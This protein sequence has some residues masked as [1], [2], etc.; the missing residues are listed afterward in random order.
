MSYYLPFILY[1]NKED[2][3]VYLQHFRLRATSGTNNPKVQSGTTDSSV[4]HEL[5]SQCFLNASYIL[6]HHLYRQN[7]VGNQDCHPKDM[8]QK[9]DQTQ[10][11]EGNCFI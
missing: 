2:Q 10:V 7:D 1:L 5:I 9:E 8:D 11:K 4:T 6:R 3:V